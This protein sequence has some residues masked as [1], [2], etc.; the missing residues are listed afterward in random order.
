MYRGTRDMLPTRVRWMLSAFRFLVLCIVGLLLLQ[1]VI[2]TM[3]K[4]SYPPIIALLQ[5]ESESMLIHKDSNFVRQEY[6]QL[7]SEFVQAFN[8]D[9]YQLDLYG[10]GPELRHGLQPDS[11]TFDQTGTDI[12]KAIQDVQR[13]YQNQNL[14]AVVLISDGISTA[15]TN[16]I[17]SIEGLRQPVYTV[18]VGDTTPQ[19][20]VKIK[21]VLFN[22]I[23]YLNN[24][25]PIRVKVQMNGY[26]QATLSVSLRSTEKVLESR[27]LRLTN[28]LP[29]GEVSFLIKPETVGLQQYEVRVSRLQNEITYRNNSRK[30]FVN[31]MENRLKVALFG[32]S[33]HPDVG[34]LVKAMQRDERY[35]LQPFL[36]RAPGRYYES[37]ANYNLSDFDLFIL[38]NFPTTSADRNMLLQIAE[39]IKERKV[40][41]MFFV[42]KFTDLR[43]MQPLYEYMGLTPKGFNLRSEE[44]ILNF[45][46]EYR[47]HSTYTF[48]DDWIQ[49]A[50]NA[51]PIFRNRSN[52]E[53][54][55]T[56]QVFATAKIKNIALDYPVYALQ[57][58]LGRK[59]MVFLGENFW[60][61]RAH[62]YVETESFDYFDEWLFNNMQWLMVQDD[63][64]RFI[65]EPSKRLF[66][67]SEPTIFKG[68]VYDD[69]YKPVPGVEIRLNLRSPDGK[70]NDYYLNEIDEAQYFLE[71]NNLTEGTYSYT[72]EGSK[73]GRPL[74][75]DRGQFSIGKSNIEHFNLQ[76]NKDLM[77][78]IAL[79]TGGEFIYARE[80]GSLPTRLKELNTLVPTTDFKRQKTDFF[81][82]WWIIALLLTMLGVEWVVRKLYSLV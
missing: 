5:D 26:E 36:L 38:H 75:T 7:L 2:T 44:V 47:Q 33:P 3:S 49:W 4:V 28:N 40:P 76:A 55:S 67:G 39:E 15:G 21:E 42:G 25:M 43:Q 52:W 56:T 80:L 53:A 22:E 70:V 61:M 63:Q 50:N 12:A 1:P 29:Q 81:E 46:P 31:V 66:S 19:R 13:L 35:E 9:E 62:S 34:A 69:S 54:K 30:L 8:P 77:E 58:H 37:P 27:Q 60:R 18:L 10:F 59:N 20:D 51:P 68:Q 65:V 23:A 79:R 78:Q 73:N 57:N 24:E 16:P 48:P 74:G 64:R 82:F 41:V 32:G 11:L 14:G 6:P 72:A 17:Y 71:L 45:S